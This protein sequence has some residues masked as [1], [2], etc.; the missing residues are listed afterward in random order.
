MSDESIKQNL[1]T[2]GGWTMV[3]VFDA[4]NTSTKQSNTG[5]ENNKAKI[6]LILGLVTIIPWVL[7]LTSYSI[8]PFSPLYL[9]IMLIVFLCIPTGIMGI[10]FGVVGFRAHKGKSVLAIILCLINLLPSVAL[11]YFTLFPVITS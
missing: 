7:I 5:V 6:A 4:L 9:L 2:G 11:A 3:E 1:M 8:A 10:V